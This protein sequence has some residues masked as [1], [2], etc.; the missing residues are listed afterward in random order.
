MY[1]IIN[2]VEPF[3]YNEKVD[4]VDHEKE[5]VFGALIRS[6]RG[7]IIV[8]EYSETGQVENIHIDDNIILKQCNNR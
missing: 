8:V 4:V 6:I 5:S 3:Y 7:N 2:K 1:Y